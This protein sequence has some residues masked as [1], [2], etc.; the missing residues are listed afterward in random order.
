MWSLLLEQEPRFQPFRDAFL[1]EWDSDGEPLPEYIC[2]SEL[3]KFTIAAFERGE[4]WA[5][6]RILTVIEGWLVDGDE[7]V[8]DLASVGFIE[9]LTNGYL[10]E[11]T[12]RED[13]VPLFS[14]VLKAEW[15]AMVGS[16]E[17]H[18]ENLKK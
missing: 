16:W 12:E 13:F 9:D 4:K 5:V 14:P 11:K 1:A 7:D 17:R 15:T 18:A 10:Y 3:A 8:A 2:V 6:Q